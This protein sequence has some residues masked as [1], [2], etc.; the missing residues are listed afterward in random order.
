MFAM[1]N[2]AELG[3][4][5]L[6]RDASAR[7]PLLIYHSFKLIADHLIVIRFIDVCA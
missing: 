2:E 4:R 3:E 5:A 1:P 7:S 6:F